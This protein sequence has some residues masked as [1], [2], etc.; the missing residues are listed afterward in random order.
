FSP[1]PEP[2]ASQFAFAAHQGILR[3]ASLYTQRC[4]RRASFRHAADPADRYR[5]S[6]LRLVFPPI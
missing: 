1:S 2:S 6:G 3:G 5:V 4:L